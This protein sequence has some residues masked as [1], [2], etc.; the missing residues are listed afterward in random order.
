MLDRYPEFKYEMGAQAPGEQPR[1][2]LPQHLQGHRV[3]PARPRRG[4]RHPLRVRVLRRRTPLQPRPLPRPRAGEAAV[5]RADHLRHPRR[6]RCG[7]GKPPPHEADRGQAVRRRLL[8]ER[9]RGGPPPARL[10][11]HE[12]NHGRQHPGRSRGQ[13]VRGQGSARQVERGAGSHR[14]LDRRETCRWRWRVRTR[15]EKCSRSREATRSGF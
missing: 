3:H 1:L 8:L 11:D 5:V 4:P 7:P 10:R 9:A 15:R 2:H 14:A 12:R 13:P 6:H